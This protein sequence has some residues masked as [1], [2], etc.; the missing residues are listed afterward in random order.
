MA[1]IYGIRN[2]ELTTSKTCNRKAVLDAIEADGFAWGVARADG[3]LEVVNRS[4]DLARK[5][6]DDRN[7]FY[8][9]QARI[10]ARN[11]RDY[12]WTVE[13]ED[14][15]VVKVYAG[16]KAA[17]AAC[18]AVE[19]VEVVEAVEAVE[20]APTAPT[21]AD[22]VVGQT[23]EVS[24]PIDG[25]DS[26]TI[27]ELERRDYCGMEYVTARVRRANGSEIT[28]GWPVEFRFDGVTIL[29]PDPSPGSF[30]GFWKRPGGVEETITAGSHFG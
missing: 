5:W 23:I 4:E 27:L 20:A 9:D 21:A 28:R 19:A 13:G 10:A 18:E 14:L 11:G 6:R 17:E 25:I 16:K 30:P 12:R 22:L 15:Q 3:T 29:D 2:N 7:E 24:D 8:R 26:L 1:T